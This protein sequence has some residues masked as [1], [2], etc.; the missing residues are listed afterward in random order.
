MAVQAEAQKAY[1]SAM[2]KAN[3][4]KKAAED[5]VAAIRAH[6][7]GS[8]VSLSASIIDSCKLE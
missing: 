8:Q 4:M 2:Q 3:L 5:K 7:N 1:D 6:R